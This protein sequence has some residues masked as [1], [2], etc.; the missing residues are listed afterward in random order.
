MQWTL[1]EWKDSETFIMAPDYK[2]PQ[3]FTE[4][5]VLSGVEGSGEACESVQFILSG[6]FRTIDLFNAGPSPVSLPGTRGLKKAVHG[7]RERRNCTQFLKH[8][9]RQ[10]RGVQVARRRSVRSWYSVER[11]R[12]IWWIL[13][14]ER[15]TREVERKESPA[16]VRCESGARISCVCI[17]C[18][19]GNRG[20]MEFCATKCEVHVIGR[21]ETMFETKCVWIMNEL[22]SGRRWIRV[23]CD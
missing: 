12:S 10:W 20:C 1:H 14:L 5:K 13:K 6:P 17:V 15:E 4:C 22:W 19:M 18:L 9:C 16:R 23:V 8:M 3:L 7:I 2:R 21:E 11:D